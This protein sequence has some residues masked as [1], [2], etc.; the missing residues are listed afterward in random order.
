MLQHFDIFPFTTIITRNAPYFS[1]G[2][3]RPIIGRKRGNKVSQYIRTRKRNMS[4]RVHDELTQQG[5]WGA[6]DDSVPHRTVHDLSSRSSR[7]TW[8]RSIMICNRDHLDQDL[9]SSSLD[10][11]ITIMP[12]WHCAEAITRRPPASM[13]LGCTGQEWIYIYIPATTRSR[14]YRIGIN[15]LFYRRSWKWVHR[16]R[17]SGREYEHLY[18]KLSPPPS[19]ETRKTYQVRVY[20]SMCA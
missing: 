18:F 10:Y 16:N 6:S 15:D 3:F 2:G 12:W 8:S 1:G 19:K 11:I 14:S 5:P 13:K 4:Y 20:V 17:W 9:S 7:S